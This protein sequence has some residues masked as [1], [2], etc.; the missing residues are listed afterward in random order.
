MIAALREQEPTVEIEIRWRLANGIP[1]NEVAEGWAKQAANEL[2][3]H[4][5]EWLSHAN[6]YGR[7]SMPLA[8][9]AYLKR[10]ASEKNCRRPGRGASGDNNKGY[11]LRKK[12][13]L[14]R[15]QPGRRSGRP[16]D[17]TISS[18]GMPS[19]VCKAD[20]EQTERPLLVM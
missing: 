6:K 18:L 4:G 16:R 2:D 8:S 13:N 9:L 17:F 12:A 1:G 10:R 3:D 15:L 5:V 19:W 14:A 11:V 7:R 20:K